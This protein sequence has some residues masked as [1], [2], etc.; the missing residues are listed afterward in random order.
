MIY[1]MKIVLTDHAKK[2]IKERGISANIVKESLM[3]PD[4]VDTSTVDKNRYLVKK[5]YFHEKFRK[6]HLLMIV[7]EK[8]KSKVVKVITIIDTSKID[9]Y[10]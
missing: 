7:C 2:R 1:N 5:I 9:K 10:F 8:E 6:K 3:F 4:N